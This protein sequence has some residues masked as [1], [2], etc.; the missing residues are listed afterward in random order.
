MKLVTLLKEKSQQIQHSNEE[1]I[2]KFEPQVR[3]FR[4][5]LSQSVYGT[6]ASD[7]ISKWVAAGNAAP[8]VVQPLPECQALYDSLRSKLGSEIHTSDWRMISQSLITEFAQLSGDSQWIHTDELRTRKESPFK[9]TVAHG[10]LLLSLL[11]NLRGLADAHQYPGSRFILNSAVHNVRFLAPVKP[12]QSIRSRSILRSVT[13]AKRSVEIHEEITLELKHSSKTA[14]VASL[15][16][17][18]YF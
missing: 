9:G 14:C 12:G 13:L 5:S 16:L 17:R 1:L 11:P 6:M 3:E 15:E 8:V 7:W 10:F 2:R 4:T 18:A